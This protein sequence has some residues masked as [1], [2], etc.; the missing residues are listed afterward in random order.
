MVRHLVAKEVGLDAGVVQLS[1]REESLADF[2]L[3]QRGNLDDLLA[4]IAEVNHSLYPVARFL[5]E[6]S[7]ETKGRWSGRFILRE[8]RWIN[9]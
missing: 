8:N 6:T 2:I 4:S 9:D 3:I 7:D 1:I 5:F